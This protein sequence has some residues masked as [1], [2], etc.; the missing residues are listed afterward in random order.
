M[1]NKVPRTA[2][3]FQRRTPSSSSSSSS[4]SSYSY[5]SSSSSSSSSSGATTSY[6]ESLG[7]LNYSFPFVSILDANS[8]II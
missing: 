7:L 5:S 3:N 6:V 8:P 1:R 4:S 2:G